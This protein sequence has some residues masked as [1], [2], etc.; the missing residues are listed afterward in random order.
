MEILLKLSN[1]N[2][3]FIQ[4]STE[5]GWEYYYLDGTTH[6]SIDGGW[7]ETDTLECDTPLTDELIGKIIQ[8]CGR[9]TPFEKELSS[10]KWQKE[11][12]LTFW[13]DFED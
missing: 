8:E 3:F 10:V 7:Y 11:T 6:K 9:A 13:D 2:Y 12:E 4:D 1:G 5:G